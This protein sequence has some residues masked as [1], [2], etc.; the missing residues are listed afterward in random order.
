MNTSFRWLVASTLFAA[1]AL[2]ASARIERIVE[3]S[4][5]VGATGHLYLETESGEIRVEPGDDAAVHV[6]ARQRIAA[7]TEAEADEL[8]RQLQLTFEHNGNAVRVVSRYARR[9]TAFHFGSW[10]PVN[11]DFIV[12][13]PRGF[14]SELVTSGGAII[15]GNLDGKASARTSGG[16][17]RFGR[18]G[19]TVSARTSG[20]SINVD[21]ARGSVELRTSGGNI[22][23]GQIAGPAEFSTSG[24]SIRA[25]SVTGALQANTSG[26]SIR[27]GLVGPLTGDSHLSTSGGS[28]RLTLDPAAAFRL[29]ASTSGGHVNAQGLTIKLEQGG[30]RSRLAGAV[31]GGGP[32]VKLRSSGG[33][34]EILGRN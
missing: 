10:P 23:V 26:G 5:A 13:V 8:L 21:G 16:S 14:Q 11:V 17:I 18:M 28:V 31:N 27:A 22:T 19:D 24:G 3:R 7:S 15:V 29:D 34:I 33:G 20:G 2:T 4:F 32:L 30:S 9:T 1:A 6:R 25:E 12:K